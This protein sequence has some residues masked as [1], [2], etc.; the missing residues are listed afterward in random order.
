MTSTR[1][2]D[3][4]GMTLS[5]GCLVHCLAL[6]A[7][8]TLSPWLAWS[9]IGNESVHLWVLILALPVALIRLGLGCRRHRR[10]GVLVAGVSGITLL[11]LALGLEGQLPATAHVALSLVGGLT[12]AF[13]HWRNF[14]LCRQ[15]ACACPS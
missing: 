6:P 3:L 15:N 13:A 1:T 10:L 12:L 8:A 11:W 2:L 4:A 9:W 14:R 7:L 5:L